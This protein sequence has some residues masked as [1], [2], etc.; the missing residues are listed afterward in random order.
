M[1]QDT[2]APIDTPAEATPEYGCIPDYAAH[3]A[4][5]EAEAAAAN[6]PPAPPVAAKRTTATAPT[7]D[8]NAAPDAAPQE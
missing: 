1:S 5:L 8:T 3:L 7:T 2:E 4:A 6:A